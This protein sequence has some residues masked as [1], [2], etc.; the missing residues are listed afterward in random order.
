ML[1]GVTSCPTLGDV[2]ARERVTDTQTLVRVQLALGA[3]SGKFAGEYEPYSS[4]DML[5]CFILK[6]P[7][8]S[9]FPQRERALSLRTALRCL[10]VR[11]KVQMKSREILRSL[12]H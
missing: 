4:L 3:G 1:A 11:L 9:C 5:S 12:R 8:L 7:L 10:R 6:S 2:P